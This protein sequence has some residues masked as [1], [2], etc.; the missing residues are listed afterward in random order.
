MLE[1]DGATKRNAWFA[2]ST[3]D[4]T[5]SAVG[6]SPSAA[7]GQALYNGWIRAAAGESVDFVFGRLVPGNRYTLCL[8]SARGRDAGNAVFTVGGESR[9]VNCTVVATMTDVPVYN[10]RLWFDSPFNSYA[11]S[12]TS[13]RMRTARSGGSSPA[14]RER[15]R[16]RS[17]ARRSRA[18]SRPMS[19]SA[20]AWSFDRTR[21]EGRTE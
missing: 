6:G 1:S 7:S 11:C 5:A 18:S 3:T 20:R 21:W 10:E 4:D 12:R 16:R 19:P 15:T 14:R 9:A 17:T 2:F 13:R 8:Y